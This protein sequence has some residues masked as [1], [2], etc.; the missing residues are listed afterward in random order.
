MKVTV[1]AFKPENLNES[2][3]EWF[4]TFRKYKKLDTLHRMV[5]Q[6]EARHQGQLQ[7]LHDINVGYCAREHELLTE[8]QTLCW[9]L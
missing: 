8:S 1:A 9:S 3:L 2:E 5:E 7:T 4:L 6:I